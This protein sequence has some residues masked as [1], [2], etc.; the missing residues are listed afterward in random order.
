MMAR[1]AQHP[2]SSGSQE[3]AE[4]QLLC[5]GNHFCRCPGVYSGQGCGAKLR[6]VQF[7]EGGGCWGCSSWPACDYKEAA[8]ERLANPQ[9]TLEAV[10][11]DVFK[12]NVHTYH[13]C[14]PIKQTE[15]CNDDKIPVRAY[16]YPTFSF[17]Q[18]TGLRK[19]LA[20][21]TKLLEV[22]LRTASIQTS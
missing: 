1:Q 4:K 15:Q 3:L 11:K 8:T 17:Q 18:S 13:Q 7:R 21:K 14:A 20:W 19:Q 12:V 10:S 22:V 2:R 5:Q 9:V 16:I 6:W